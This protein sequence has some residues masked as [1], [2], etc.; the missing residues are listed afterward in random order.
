V[1]HV[2]SSRRTTW[3]LITGEYPPQSGGVS[4]YTRLVARGL[5][6]EGEEVHVWASHHDSSSPQDNG[7]AVH[8]LPDHFGIRSLRI[9]GSALNAWP[10]P[11]RILVQYVP[12][13]FGWKAMNLNFCRWLQ[14]R[15][16]PVWIMFHEVAFGWNAGQPIKHRVLAWANRLMA[17]WATRSAERIFVSIPTWAQMVE[18]FDST[19]HNRTSWTPVPSNVPT[20]V[21]QQAA[22][23]RRDRLGIEAES[24]VVGHFGTYGGLIEPLLTPLLTDLLRRNP[25]V[26]CLLM[27]RNSENYAKVFREHADQIHATGDMPAESVSECLAACDVVLQPYPDGISCRRGS[28]MAALALGRPIVSTLGFLSESFWRQTNA[29]SLGAAEHSEQLISLV[30]DLLADRQKRCE[31]GKQAKRLYDERFSLERTV[32]VLLG[33]ER[34]LSA[35]ATL[36]V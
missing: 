23:N 28:V 3:H 35:T 10:V 16:Q 27:G 8:R 31:M 1:E 5:A 34:P 19:A 13:A 36:K 4:D 9:L 6:T 25:T 17:S 30:E 14:F 33:N 24:I 11:S 26:H 7:V 15:K 2:V 29:V 20:Q 12:H 32:Q 18:R 22:R 21:D